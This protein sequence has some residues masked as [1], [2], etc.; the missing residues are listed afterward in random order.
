MKFLDSSVFLHAFLRPR[1]KL[2][3]EEEMLKKRAKKIIERIDSSDEYVLTTVIH[4]SELV[5]MIESWL[6]LRESLSVLA[7]LL[8]LRNIS[9]VEVSERDYEEALTISIHYKVSVNDA[10]AYL[11]MKENNVNEIYTFDKHFKNLPG[12]KI[13]Q[14]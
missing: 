8:S 6:G 11:K 4:V 13:R 7:R 5:N 9:I 3:P 10:I 12:I 14:E 1:R 2:K